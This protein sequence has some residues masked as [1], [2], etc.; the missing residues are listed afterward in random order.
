MN[1]PITPRPLAELAAMTSPVAVPDGQSEAIR[2]VAFDTQTY[3]QAGS[4]TLNFF[5]AVNADQTISNMQQPGS[6]PDPQ[7][8]EI[9]QI[10]CDVLLPATVVAAPAAFA[11]MINLIMVGRPL[12]SLIISDKRYVQVPLSFCH[13]SGGA[14]AFGYNS[15]AVAAVAHEFANNGIFDGG[16]WIDGSIT[17]PPKVGFQVRIDWGNAQ[18]VL[19]NTLIRINLDGVLHRRVL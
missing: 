18:A 12:L 1:F 10:S 15:A 9:Y 13:A 4:A 3:L 14:Q 19:A 2:W 5:Q 17:I 8:M 16:F 7:Y 6:F 11:D